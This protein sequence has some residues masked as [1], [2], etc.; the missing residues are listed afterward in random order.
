M[1]GEQLF[2]DLPEQDRPQVER[3]GAARLRVPERNQIGMQVA[4]LDDLVSDD[5][6]VR[7][8]WAFVEG[9]DLSTLHDAVKARE[10]QPG[11]PP[12]APKLMLALWLS[13]SMGTA[14][15]GLGFC[16]K[17]IGCASGKF[18]SLRVSGSDFIGTC[19]TI[20]GLRSHPAGRGRIHR[21]AP[22]SRRLTRRATRV[23]SRMAQVNIRSM[24]LKT[25]VIPI[26]GSPLSS[27][28]TVRTSRWKLTPILSLPGRGACKHPAFCRNETRLH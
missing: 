13:R 14:G 6:P 23:T 24:I 22:L 18:G 5:H 4:A 25:S 3:R 2:E 15:S 26:C 17:P 7:A 19:S 11:H 20:S 28:S 27:F 9:L 1:A 21:M 12:A 16:L 10:G 8:V